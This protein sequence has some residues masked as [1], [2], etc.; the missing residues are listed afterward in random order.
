DLSGLAQPSPG[1]A[2]IDE[3]HEAIGLPFEPKAFPVEIL[4]LS[5]Q[6]GVRLRA[7]ISEFG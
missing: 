1:H 5:A 7:T 3:R 2:K 4:T 6:N